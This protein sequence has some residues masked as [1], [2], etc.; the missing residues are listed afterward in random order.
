MMNYDVSS[1]SLVAVASLLVFAYVA[2]LWIY[3]QTYQ[4]RHIPTV[5]APGLLGSYLDA[6]KFTRRGREL[7]QKGYEKVGAI[8]HLLV[9]LLNCTQFYGTAFKVSTIGRYFVVVSGPEM[10]DDIRKATDDQL[11]F[12]QA[13][14]ELLQTDYMIGPQ[15]RTDPFHVAVV[16]TTLTRNLTSRFEDLTDELSAA[17]A[18][19]IPTEWIRLPVMSTV[20]QVVCRTSN[21]LFVGLPLCRVPEYRKLHEQMAAEVIVGS[22]KINKFPQLLRPLVGQLLTKVPENIERLVSH[23]GPLVQDRLDKEDMFGPDWPDKPNDLLTWLL[24][25][26]TGHQRTVREIAVRLLS[27]NF[28]AIHTTSMALT[29]AIYDLAAYPEYAAPLREEVAEVIQAEGWTKMAQGRMRKLDSFLKESQRLAV[30]SLVM[31]RL[32]LKD[33]TFSN[34]VTVPS[35]TQ[36]AFATRAT[37]EDE[38]NFKDPYKFQGFRF[39]EMREE[40]TEKAKHQ[41]TSLSPEYILFG[42]GRHACPGRFFAVNELKAMLAYILLNYDI[43]L[44]DGNHRPDNVWVGASCS[45]NP[46]AEVLLRKR[47]V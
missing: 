45:P 28:A 11:S 20:R 2:S 32:V 18:E 26:G 35:G 41:M 25:E 47:V 36:L 8:C 30:A 19:L 10:F 3:S 39:A 15:I 37:H 5:G 22:Q 16:R 23:I 40:D 21:R 6:W 7:V 31:N 38:L 1:N 12:R 29:H 43:K 44:V 46:T 14:A 27:V 42:T 24:E 33:F 17:F 9:P 13:I 34:G 4:L